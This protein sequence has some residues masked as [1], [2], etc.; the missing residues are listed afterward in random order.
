MDGAPCLVALQVA[1]QMPRGIEEIRKLRL[2][3]LKLLHAILAENPQPCIVCGTNRIRRK[4]FRHCDER[5]FFRAPPRTLRRTRDSLSHFRKI[6]SDG[7]VLRRHGRILARATFCLS[8]R[9]ALPPKS[10]G[11]GSLTSR[12]TCYCGRDAPC[13]R[14]RPKIGRAHV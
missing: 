2:L 13:T 11:A 12:R 5:D 4:C 7:N 8:L 10:T 14:T 9:R 6:S 1:D 3:R